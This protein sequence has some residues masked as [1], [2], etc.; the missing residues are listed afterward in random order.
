[1]GLVKRALSTPDLPPISRNDDRVVL[2]NR[3][4]NRSDGEKREAK[5][6]EEKKM[7]IIKKKK[8]RIF[9]LRGEEESLKCHAQPAKEEEKVSEGKWGLLVSRHGEEQRARKREC[10]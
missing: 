10:M 9:C 4:E 8:K 1:M 3:L 2:E 6:W 7:M 5:K